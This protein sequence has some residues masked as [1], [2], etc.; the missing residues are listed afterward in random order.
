M[1][2]RISKRLNWPC[3][4]TI[5]CWWPDVA[6]IAFVVTMVVFEEFGLTPPCCTRLCCP[7]SCFVLKPSPHAVHGYGWSPVCSL[8]FG[9][10]LINI[11]SFPALKKGWVKNTY[12]I[13]ATSVRFCR[14]SLPQTVHECGTWPWM[15]PWLTSWN[16]RGN[17]APQSWHTNGFTE[18]WKRECITKWFSWAKLSPQ[19][20]HT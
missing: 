13:W 3:E 10:D 17:V 2:G 4:L 14:N 16:L 20:S 19:S 5:T 6:T 1:L 7:S 18:P 15:R 11:L 12:L 9:S 8:Q